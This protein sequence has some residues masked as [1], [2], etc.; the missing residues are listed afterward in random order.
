MT[1]I[2][3]HP[4]RVETK[5]TTTKQPVFIEIL[6]EKVV[7]P[8]Q[9]NCFRYDASE[10]EGADCKYFAVYGDPRAN[11]ELSPE[12]LLK[13]HKD[14]N[15]IVFLKRP[16]LSKT[17]CFVFMLDGQ[18]VLHS[19]KMRLAT[20]QMLSKADP[21]EFMKSELGGGA[22]RERLEKD[23]KPTEAYLEQLKDTF[24]SHGGYESVVKDI[25]R[26]IHVLY[27]NSINQE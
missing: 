7:R 15:V 17:K 16:P 5:P 25:T 2:P 26:Y 6:G 11:P 3:P 27:E 24:L 9:I 23:G 14:N 1:L 19:R 22:P 21:V 4:K 12:V 20:A 8:K 10:V 18:E 13:A